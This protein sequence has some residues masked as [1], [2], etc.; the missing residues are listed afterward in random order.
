MAIKPFI[1][2]QSKSLC[3]RRATRIDLLLL[4]HMDWLAVYPRLAGE[5]QQVLAF[6]STCQQ[7]W[8]IITAQVH[9]KNTHAPTV[10]PC[11]QVAQGAFAFAILADRD[12]VV[13]VFVLG[14]QWFGRVFGQ[15]ALVFFSAA[16]LL[17]DPGLFLEI[18]NIGEDRRV[19]VA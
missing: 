5:K 3:Y 15:G 18:F 12:D 16:S 7:S 14:R 9:A 19:N 2:F 10:L 1:W 13:V 6:L 8:F 11:I 17:A 4:N